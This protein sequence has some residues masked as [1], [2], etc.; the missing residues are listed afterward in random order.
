MDFEIDG[1]EVDCKYSK[2]PFGWMIPMET[3]GHH[4]MLCHANEYSAT[5]RIG[6]LEIT[7]DFLNVGG[8][9]DRKRTINLQGRNAI[10]W[11]W[12]DHPYPQ[13]VLLHLEDDVIDCIMNPAS[14][15]ERVNNLFRSVQNQIIPRGIVCTVAQQKDPMKRVRYN[16]G[17]RS[18][19]RPEGILIL[20]D[21]QRH[22]RIAA[23]LNLPIPKD[24][25]NVAV[26]VVPTSAG[27]PKPVSKIGET[28]WKIAAEND[29]VFEA[30]VVPEK[31]RP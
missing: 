24:G 22:V 10:E 27:A 3:V 8:N 23:D 28:Y 29:P 12:F 17:A 19:L 31:S 14:G 7:D 13:N 21:Y 4:A 6:F 5:F 2:Q 16:G 15:Q 18:H 25:D 9:R 20:G 30:P 11:A 1:M 26:R